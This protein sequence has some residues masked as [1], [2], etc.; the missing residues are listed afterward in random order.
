M[1]EKGRLIVTYSVRLVRAD[2][3][4][5]HL[6]G[7]YRYK[8][9]LFSTISSESHLLSYLHMPIS[10]FSTRQNLSSDL[11]LDGPTKLRE[12]FRFA[13]I[14]HCYTAISMHCP[15]LIPR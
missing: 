1:V 11:H 9:L 12:L 8:Y 15:L 5:E 13:R 4:D 10:P 2:M 7:A 3:S 6:L 14:C